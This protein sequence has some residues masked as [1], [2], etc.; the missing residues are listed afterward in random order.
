MVARATIDG[1][2][3]LVGKPWEWEGEVFQSDPDLIDGRGKT[4]RGVLSNSLRRIRLRESLGCGMGRR[5]NPSREI[6]SSL[7]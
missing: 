5:G 1:C 6:W 2:C 4:G 7:E 3:A